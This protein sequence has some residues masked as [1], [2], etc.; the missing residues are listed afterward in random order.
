LVTVRL[1]IWRTL[2]VTTVAIKHNKIATF[3]TRRALGF[4]SDRNKIESGESGG[5]CANYASIFYLQVKS[6]GWGEYDKIRSQLSEER[7]YDAIQ[8]GTILLYL[9]QQKIKSINNIGTWDG[10][11]KK[12]KKMKKIINQ[13]Q[14]FFC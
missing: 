7:G 3:G 11:T 8:L 13:Y 5:C 1:L 2:H 12:Y 14:M 4:T 9:M 10:S 6:V